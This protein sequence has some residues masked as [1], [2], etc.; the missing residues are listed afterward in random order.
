MAHPNRTDNTFDQSF[1]YNHAGSMTSNSSVG[2]YLYSAFVP[3]FAPETVNGTTLTYDANGNMLSGYDGKV[4]TYDAENRPLSVTKGGVTTTYTYGADG[5]RLKKTVSSDTTVTFGPVEIRAFTPTTT[6]D[7]ITY[8]HGDI[9]LVN[10]TDEALHRDQLAS[11]RAITDA[12]G[13]LISETAYRPFGEIGAESTSV[14]VVN[15]TKGFIGERY[16]EDAGLQYLNARYYDPELGIFIQPD[17]WEVTRPGVGTNRYAYSANDPV[18]ASD[19][20]GNACTMQTSGHCDRAEKYEQLD[21]DPDIN[22]ETTFLA[23]AGIV[24]SSLGD[25]DR[26]ELWQRLLSGSRVYATPAVREFLEAVGQDLYEKNAGIAEALMAGKEVFGLNPSEAS[27]LEIDQAWVRFEQGIVQQHLDKLQ[28]SD[29]R[30]HS[31]VLNFSNRA[32]D[33][34]AREGA[35]LGVFGTNVARLA[36]PSSAA[37][38]DVVREQLGAIP[39]SFANISHRIMMGDA[40]TRI[41][42]ERRALE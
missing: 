42:R 25:A 33:E 9:R 22:N 40:V 32:I 8:P 19:P 2:S 37:A 18:N 3:A 35:V 29:R 11:L 15:E 12:S 10:G 27:V 17:W 30:A 23:A 36:N 41:V 13:A 7:V 14:G 1:T 38:A 28:S 26:E 34:L 5:S 31:Q 39:W 16:D 24:A 4:M 21:N 20:G 6:G